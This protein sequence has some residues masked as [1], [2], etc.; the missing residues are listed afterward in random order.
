MDLLPV[1]WQA[2]HHL[3]EA[4]LSPEKETRHAA[5][6]HSHF[7]FRNSEVAERGVC[8]GVKLLLYVM[9]SATVRDD[10]TTGGIFFRRFFIPPSLFF[11]A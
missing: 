6:A 7:H 4:R 10:T 9:F 1:K 11:F 3:D 2:A 5:R 8:G